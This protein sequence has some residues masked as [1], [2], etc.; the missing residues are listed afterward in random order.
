CQH[1]HDTPLTF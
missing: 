1:H